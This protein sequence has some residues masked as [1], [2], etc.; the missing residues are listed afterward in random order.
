M[1]KSVFFLLSILLA[2]A[3][4]S[5]TERVHLASQRQADPVRVL[6]TNESG[7][8]IAIEPREWQT[9]QRVVESGEA[10]TQF[11]FIAANYLTQP[12]NPQI[13]YSVAVIGIPVGATVRYQVLETET[14]PVDAVN[15]LPFPTFIEGENGPESKYET[16][17]EIYGAPLPF[18]SEIVRVEEPGLFR[19]Q[20]VVRVVVA[21]LQYFPQQKRVVKYEKVVL[22]IEFA[23]GS[24]A[25]QTTP[26]SLSRTDEPLYKSALINYGQSRSW[27]RSGRQQQSSAN[28]DRLSSRNV[29]GTLY[30]FTVQEEGIY[31]IDGQ[32]LQSHNINLNDVDPAM[33]RLYSNGGRE[34]PRALDA[35]RPDGLVENAIIVSDGGDGN[36]DADD[37]ILFYGRGVRG[38][39]YDASQEDFSHYINHYTT[40]NIYWLSF[41][42]TDAGKR[43]L[44][45]SSGP[46]T[47]EVVETYQG[48]HF[49]EEE[50]FNPLNSGLNF[51]GREF[52]TDPANRTQ[53]YTPDLPNAL[54]TGT[55]RLKA[56]FV[57]I[58]AGTHAFEILVN[59][60]R[61]GLRQVPGLSLELGQYL[62]LHAPDVLPIEMANLLRP[63]SNELQITY[64]NTSSAGQANL[65]WIELLYPARMSA[66]EDEL[67]FT[68]APPS[69]PTTYRV[70]NFTSDAIRLFDV[71]E[72]ADVAEMTGAVSNGA[73]TFTDQEATV[74]SK[75]FLALTPAKF[76]SVETLERVEVS[77]LRR[78]VS[79]A[80]FIIITH[81]DFMNQAALVEGLRE[82][83]SSDNR[84]LTEVV[85]TREIY[86]NFS[87]GLMDPT[88]IRDFLKYAYENWS[89]R[90][91]YVLLLGDGDYD[92]KNIVSRADANWVP[93]YQS[94]AL[95][96]GNTLRA[97]GTRT[98]D[99]WFTYVSG[100][101]T[102]MDLAI[103]R[104]N[105][106][107]TQ[108]AANAVNKLI[109]YETSPNYDTWRNTITIVG[110]DELN[111]GGRPDSRDVVHILQAED[112]AE[113]YVPETF[114][115]RKIYL[116]E[117]PA[118]I[119]ASVGGKTKPGARNALIEQLNEGTVIVN[120]IGHG[121]STQWA[122]ELVFQRSDNA[123]VQNE[124]KLTFFVAA[125]CDWALY[126]NPQRQSQAEQLLLA[127][128]RGAIAI[129]SSARLVFSNQN[130]NFNRNYY[131]RLL[132][133]D[134]VGMTA[135]I[136]DA[137][138]LTRLNSTSTTTNDEKFHIYGDP[139]LR[140]AVPRQR[141]VITSVVPDSI[142]ALSTV[143]ITGEILQ[144]GQ[145]WSDFNGTALV[146]TSDSKQFVEHIPEAGGTQRYFL[147]G[148]SIYRGTV[149]VQNGRFNARFIVPKDISYGGRL[150]RISTYFWN[151][152]QTVDGAG[153]MDSIRV[154]RASSTLADAKGPEIKLSFQGY[155]NFTSGEIVGE[156]V[157][158]VAELADT[159]SG[160]NI[161]G[162]IGHRI[163]LSIDPEQETCLS[164]RNEFLGISSIDLT[165][166]F[167]FNEGDHLRG[168]IEFPIHFPKEVEVGGETIPC[169][170]FGG[171]D[172]HTLVLKAWDNANNSSTASLEVLVAHEEGLVLEKV[173]NYP[174]PFREE[175]TFTFI[176]NQDTEAEVKI[177]TISGQ[178]IKTLEEP[179]A[180]RGFN[181][182]KWNGKDAD[183]DIPANGVY[184]YKLI[185]RSRGF[186]G[187]EQREKIGKLAIVR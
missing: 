147:P 56:R 34:L 154:S 5:Q 129:L 88:A 117:Y 41:E 79:G 166:Q 90:P 53:T 160:I 106:Q 113:N 184:F 171:E 164:Q 92:Y 99:S 65:D 8:T 179:F 16:K 122:H 30:K 170:G 18:P 17:D 141:A 2:N 39:S 118:V 59:G 69:G 158:L 138:V 150:A 12:G 68:V 180:A 76:K 94:D 50:L 120:Y 32:L 62:R 3:S 137:F 48:L 85:T 111:S 148:N 119:S 126:D 153:A 29:A 40:E 133:A 20:Q 26:G 146:T 58:N 125:T 130:A 38:W 107:S 21:G 74:Q 84:L 135:R 87:G 136:G 9:R 116:S 104:I 10:F 55:A 13:P 97:L 7:L 47:G 140:L 82:N 67:A 105:A 177:Y 98:S 115:V 145:L 45:V 157:V 14:E 162:E 161:A 174:N 168:R 33:I 173:M 66:V 51:F 43:M 134:G 124:G 83:L 73:I 109:A 44:Q 71:T 131:R 151:E 75:R 112:L 142:V 25:S 37:S 100:N 167:R 102:V 93:T 35:P 15:L 183:G 103:G 46:P 22:R 61:V 64:S 175:T 54:P 60:T 42:G 86:N 181:M 19:D 176:T 155:E 49:I 31:R 27:R 101:D 28:L 149:P 77:D 6:S 156:N 78:D 186:D 63:G 178:L 165:D 172:R 123:E 185:I 108:D 114:N 139:T 70:R 182:I 24:R 144:D 163:T 96:S 11:D 159:V 57:S 4:L 72:F 110:D 36:F 132:P 152:D 127:E 169:T 1:K 52:T 121:N 128:N 23:G 91:A 89:P 95:A 80:E 143:D 81:E 187:V